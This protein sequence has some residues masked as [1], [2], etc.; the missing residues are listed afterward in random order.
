MA[1]LTLL[2]GDLRFPEGPVWLDDGAVVVVEIARQA[3]TR[4]APDGTT[5]LVAAVPGGPNGAAL[6]PGGAVYL[7]NNGGYFDWFEAGGALIPGPTPATYRGG[8]IERV[9]PR[10]GELELLHTHCDGK[11][12]VAPNDL[13]FDA[14]GGLWFTDH[15]VQHGDHAD[16]PGLL[17]LGPGGEAVTGAV[18]G[19]DSANGVGLSPDGRTVYVAETHPGRLWAFDVV[20]PGQ[21]A[22]GGGPD[23]PHAGR[24]LYDAPEGQ[25]F[26]SLA[27]DGDGWVCV[28]TIGP[29]A[30]TCVS[31]DGSEVELVD[32]DDPLTTNIAFGGADGRT[33]V[34][35]L[36]SS[37]RV[38]TLPWSRPGLRLAFAG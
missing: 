20:G 16:Q 38:A 35:T 29:G 4:I 10:T 6:G 27:V 1:D 18:W 13:V 5:T 37:G 30:I 23:R 15:G 26:D 12:L 21:V 11:P 19:L 34:V 17:H 9:D 7:C 33:A 2:A 14:D 28:A 3:L 25:L 22:N 31:P 36:S 8:S 24:L 32:T